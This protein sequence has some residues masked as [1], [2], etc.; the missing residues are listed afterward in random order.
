MHAAG[1]VCQTGLERASPSPRLW[2]GAGGSYWESRSRVDIRR[3]VSAAG[4]AFWE[5]AELCG[6]EFVGRICSGPRISAPLRHKA[7]AAILR[8]RA[9][10]GHIRP[11]IPLGVSLGACGCVDET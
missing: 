4:A 1:F 2:R 10:W 5:G 11:R 7:V 8:I 6:S 9:L 3:G